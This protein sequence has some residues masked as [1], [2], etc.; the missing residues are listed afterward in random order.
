MLGME[1]GDAGCWEAVLR[2]Y[3]PH[4]RSWRR[5]GW[6]DQKGKALAHPH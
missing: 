3:H 5:L 6:Q 4:S 1:V 2:G